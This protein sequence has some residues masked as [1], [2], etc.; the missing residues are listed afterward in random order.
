M[1]EF[2][3]ELFQEIAR[4]KAALAQKNVETSDHELRE[5]K[6]E[7]QIL[8]RQHKAANSGDNDLGGA[9]D[10][11][12]THLEERLT[13]LL[14]QKGALEREIA[15]LQIETSDHGHDEDSHIASLA[16]LQSI[17]PVKLTGISDTEISGVIAFGE[18]AA[19]SFFSVSRDGK[20]S[21][22]FWEAVQQS[23][24]CLKTI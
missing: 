14:G 8:S 4:A 23:K 6:Q 20:T 21:E 7:V 19:T 18:A 1:M 2:P 24:A 15:S 17:A 16:V 12:T 13:Q 5:L 9:L 3:T 11:T 22:R 10:D